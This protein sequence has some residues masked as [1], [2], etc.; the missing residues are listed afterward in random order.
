MEL[1]VGTDINDYPIDELV[2]VLNDIKK[3]AEFIEWRSKR[4]GKDAFRR[5]KRNFRD[6]IKEMIDWREFSDFDYNK[7]TFYMCQQFRGFA[8]D[9]EELAEWL[10]QSYGGIAGQEIIIELKKNTQYRLVFRTLDWW[11]QSEGTDF[12]NQSKQKRLRDK[13][14]WK[15][16]ESSNGMTY[17]E[18]GARRVARNMA[19]KTMDMMAAILHNNPKRLASALTEGA[20]P[21]ARVGED[22][23]PLH[24]LPL[25]LQ[26]DWDSYNRRYIGA[27]ALTLACVKARSD[28]AGEKTHNCANMLMENA[29]VDLFA[30]WQPING[31]PPTT[32]MGIA[33]GEQDVQGK[34]DLLLTAALLGSASRCD[35][36]L[37]ENVSYPI[38]EPSQLQRLRRAQTAEGD[39][40]R[41]LIAALKE[42]NPRPNDES[43]DELCQSGCQF[44]F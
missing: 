37:D 38:Y 31:G 13:K 28:R 33:L 16:W 19:Q 10:D 1:P 7:K 34:I 2:E 42:C 32:A 20:D 23:L 30:T 4:L 41:R 43:N 36:H 17:A 26:F 39:E 27:P 40:V 14:D 18:N 29:R 6:L 5:A 24:G 12:S 3:K 11:E 35:P 21:N 22:N 9:V 25:P 8:G 15:E 44:K